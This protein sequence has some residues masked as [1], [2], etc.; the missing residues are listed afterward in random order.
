MGSITIIGEI[1]LFHVVSRGI[2]LDID[3]DAGGGTGKQ[4]SHDQGGQCQPP[5]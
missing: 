5:S 3:V 1:P 4:G 2:D